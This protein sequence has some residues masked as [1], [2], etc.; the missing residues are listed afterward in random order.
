MNSETLHLTVE[1]NAYVVEVDDMAALPLTVRVN[2]KRFTVV[3]RPDEP[4]GE[5]A[6]AVPQFE[7]APAAGAAQGGPQEMTAPMPGT[8]LD[9][10]VAV[11]DRVTFRQLLCNLEAMKMKNA[12]RAPREGTVVAV[13]VREGQTV[14]HGDRLFTLE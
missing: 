13:H 8:I 5:T 14:A 2:G 1:G 6:D 4:A 3:L 7:A 11:G 12:L 9:I 10:A